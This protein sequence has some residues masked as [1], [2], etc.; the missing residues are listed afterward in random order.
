LYRRG[1][2]NRMHYVDQ[3]PYIQYFVFQF[4]VA[5]SCCTLQFYL[6]RVLQFIIMVKGNKK[7]QRSRITLKKK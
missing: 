1:Y 5:L 2:F 6:C 7:T 3:I 4:H